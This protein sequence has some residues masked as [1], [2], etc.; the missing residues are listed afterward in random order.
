MTCFKSTDNRI[1]DEGAKSLCKALKTNTTL[2]KLSLESKQ[3]DDER[4]KSLFHFNSFE[5]A[6]EIRDSGTAALCE[7]FKTNTA[8]TSVNLSGKNKSFEKQPESD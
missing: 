4:K 8:L 1:G 5:K 3:S 2:T 7:A 6:N